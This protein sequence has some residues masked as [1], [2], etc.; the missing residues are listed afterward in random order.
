MALTGRHSLLDSSAPSIL[1]SQVRI[2][3]TP[4][5]LLSSN[6]V[7]YLSLYLEKDENK[8]KEAGLGQ[9]LKDTMAFVLILWHLF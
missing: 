4:S 2:P 5:M 8:H 3:S 1:R 6:I 9:C 7:L